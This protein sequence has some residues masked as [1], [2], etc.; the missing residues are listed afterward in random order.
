MSYPLTT[1]WTTNS[2]F[3]YTD[4]NNINAAVNYAWFSVDDGPFPVRLATTGAE[5][6]TIASGSVTTINGT[7]IDGVT[8]QVGDPILIKDAPAS[9]GAGSVN[10]LQ[11]GNG[12]YFATAVATNISV[13]RANPLLGNYGPQSIYSG[14]SSPADQVA[15]ISPAGTL[16]G[17]SIWQVLAPS[18]LTTAFTYGTTSMQWRCLYGGAVSI[19]SGQATSSTNQTQ[20]ASYRVPAN[21]MAAGTS[22]KVKVFGTQSTT[23]GTI[24]YQIH[25]GTA[26]TTADAV[27]ANGA[28]PAVAASGTTWFDGLFTCRTTG[29]AGTCIAGGVGIG[30]TTTVSTTTGT[31]TVNTTVQN[32]VSVS[33]AASAGTHTAQNIFIGPAEA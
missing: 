30:S 22:Y 28:S 27:I 31:A 3:A 8:V 13:A 29:S 23:S 17:G 2:T 20:L 24:A 5:T 33:A 26:N 9:T 32:F 7:T 6:F 12:I 4:Q 18:N 25:C 10:S 1:A 15:I 11:P 16:N 21:A 19:T 14:Q